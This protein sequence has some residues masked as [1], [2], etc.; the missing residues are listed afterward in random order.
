VIEPLVNA[1]ASLVMKESRVKEL[2][3]LITVMIV[4]PAG[5]RSTWLPMLVETM[6]W[7]GTPSNMLDVSVILDTEDLPVSSKS[8]HL[9]PILLSV[10]VMRLVAI[11]LEEVSV[12]TLGGLAHALL[13]SLA[14]DVSIKPLSCK[15]VYRL[16]FTVLYNLQL[17]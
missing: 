10:M 12:T 7:C 6:I 1:N 13:A 2:S 16:Y 17:T 14:L 15:F 11:A 8:A 4:E 5:Q 9:V 3:V